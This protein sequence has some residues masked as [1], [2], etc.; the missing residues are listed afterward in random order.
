MEISDIKKN[1]KDKNNLVSYRE[2][3]T[4]W[5]RKSQQGEGGSEGRRRWIAMFNQVGKVGFNERVVFQP[6]VKEGDERMKQVD[7]WE[8]EY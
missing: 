5:K 3:S 2:I 6:R 7:I 4:I 8:T 1:N